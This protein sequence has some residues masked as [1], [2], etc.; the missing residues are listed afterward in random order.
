MV[1]ECVHL[2]RGMAAQSRTILSV[3]AARAV[4]VTDNLVKITPK[5]RVSEVLL[6]VIGTWCWSLPW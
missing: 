5:I 1:D 6:V 4:I 2:H 3:A